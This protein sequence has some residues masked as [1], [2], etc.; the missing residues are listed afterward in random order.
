MV[1]VTRYNFSKVDADECGAPYNYS[2]NERR[3]ISILS[4][5][6]FSDSEA[7]RV[8]IKLVLTRDNPYLDSDVDV[9]LG[10]RTNCIVQVSAPSSS[11][12]ARDAS[13]LEMWTDSRLYFMLCSS[14]KPLC[15]AV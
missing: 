7:Q 14:G 5:R 4:Y 10:C 12:T 15:G 3:K 13:R 11:N 6:G 9:T 2:Q 8:F 1:N